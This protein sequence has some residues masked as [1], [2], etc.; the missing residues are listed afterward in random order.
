MYQAAEALNAE[1][2]LLLPRAYAQ[3]PKAAAHLENS[4][5]SVQF[6]TGEGIGTFMPNMKIN[7]YEIAR[8]EANEVRSVLRRL[9]IGRV[10]TQHEIQKAYDLAG[11]IVGMLTAA[12]KAVENRRDNPATPAPRSPA[13]TRSGPR[14]HPSPQPPP[15]SQEPSPAP[16]D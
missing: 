3:K 1:I 5:N 6:N 13:E 4:G 12:I 2:E 9:V 10:F 14:A 11:S 15:V 7:A 16:A 8:K